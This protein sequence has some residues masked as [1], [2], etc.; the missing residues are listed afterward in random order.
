MSSWGN[1]TQDQTNRLPEPKPT[2]LSQP[3]WQAC[4][5]GKLLVQ[6][7]SQ[8]AVYIF[9][10][11]PVCPHCFKASL[12]WQQSSGKGRLYSFTVVHRPQTPAF[13]TPY[14]AAIVALDEGWHMLSNI[15]DCR[16]EDLAIDKPLEVTFVKRGDRVL[17][18]FKPA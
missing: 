18:F 8:C 15:I 16:I 3:H 13:N 9:P 17:P 10:P 11:E 1:E 4:K 7:C 2:E 5:D 12:R 14:I 6:Q